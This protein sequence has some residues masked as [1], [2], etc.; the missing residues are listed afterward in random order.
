MRCGLT[1]N[2]WWD[3]AEVVGRVLYERLA[4]TIVNRT[5]RLL[6]LQSGNVHISV[7]FPPVVVPFLSATLPELLFIGKCHGRAYFS[8]TSAYFG[9]YQQCSS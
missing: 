3:T 6:M 2:E 5:Q 4:S 9:S 7:V 1:D 8:E